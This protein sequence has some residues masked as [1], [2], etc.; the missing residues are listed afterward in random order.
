M[1][2]T[3]TD[4]GDDNNYTNKGMAIESTLPVRVVLQWRVKDNEAVIKR[5]IIVSLSTFKPRD[6]STHSVDPNG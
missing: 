4:G 1:T 2:T 3:M 6:I 5:V